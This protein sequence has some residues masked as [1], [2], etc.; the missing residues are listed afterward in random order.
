[1][2]DN[3]SEGQEE[4]LMY[5]LRESLM[6][7]KEQLLGGLAQDEKTLRKLGFMLDRVKK[8]QFSMGPYNGFNMNR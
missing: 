5:A 2:L 6:Q 1:M 8:R 3:L 7:N 4:I